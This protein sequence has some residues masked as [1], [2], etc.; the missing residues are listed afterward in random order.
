[1]FPT[2][3]ELCWNCDFCGKPGIVISAA[4]I[5]YC[6]WCRKSYG[7]RLENEIPKN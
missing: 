6:K 3:V 7:E 1:M 2:D 5:L 4:G